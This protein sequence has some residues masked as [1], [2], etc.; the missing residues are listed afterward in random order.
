VLPQ[1]QPFRKAPTPNDITLVLLPDEDGTADELHEVTDGARKGQNL[2]QKIDKSKCHRIPDAAVAGER[3]APWGVPDYM[4]ELS[5]LATAFDKSLRYC[6]ERF[7]TVAIRPSESG[8]RYH[9][10]LGFAKKK[11]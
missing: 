2:Y 9:P 10:A 1:Q 3:I 11:D 7:G 8:W 5:K 4:D 6:A